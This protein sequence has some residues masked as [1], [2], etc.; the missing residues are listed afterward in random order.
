MRE[1]DGQ[2]SR[3]QLKPQ[4]PAALC[5]GQAGQAHSLSATAVLIPRDS[6]LPLEA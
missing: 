2:G 3:T 6:P 5:V 4:S 1:T